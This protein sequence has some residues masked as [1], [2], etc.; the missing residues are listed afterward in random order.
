MNKTL[1][2]ERIVG[3]QYQVTVGNNDFMF[4][5]QGAAIK[6]ATLA[7]YSCTETK[8]DEEPY[9]VSIRFIPIM[10]KEEEEPE[11]VKESEEVKEDAGEA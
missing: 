10:E 7:R 4:S 6:F 1:N 9:E 2:I 3:I 11:E 5:E 8:W